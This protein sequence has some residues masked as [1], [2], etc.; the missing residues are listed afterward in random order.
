MSNDARMRLILELRQKGIT[1]GRVLAAIERTPRADFVESHL[2][3][4]GWA[5]AALPLIDGVEAPPPSECARMLMALEPS[6]EDVVLEVGVGSGW[7]SAVLSRLCARVIGLERR[8]G[9]ASAAR[10]R[11]RTRAYGLVDVYCADG[12]LGWPE[13]APYNRII[14]NA[15]LKDETPALFAQL[16]PGGVIVAPV[17]GERGQRIM[18]MR[19]G[20]DGGFSVRVFGPS[21]FAPIENGLVN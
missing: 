15:A 13:S 7:Q 20:E 21:R 6:E 10:E 8:A 2:E 5:D 9:L 16:K 14:V 12:L 11:L 1:D 3:S 18:Q 17:E 19:R 4:L